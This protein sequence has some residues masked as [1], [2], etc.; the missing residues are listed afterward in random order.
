MKAKTKGL[1]NIESIAFI[2]KVTVWNRIEKGEPIN[3]PIKLTKVE[4]TILDFLEKDPELSKS[5]ISKM[6]ELSESSVK[7]IFNEL[8][9]RGII[10]HFGP[11]KTG[12]W[13]ILKK[14]NNS[15][16]R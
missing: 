5:K 9:K 10:K 15:R 1:K 8:Q 12:Y 4:K 6:I 7:R 13:K 2:L 3:E 16:R 11:N 14:Q